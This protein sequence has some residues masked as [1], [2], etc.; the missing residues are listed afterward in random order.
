MTN[1]SL[2]ILLAFGAGF[3]FFFLK[4]PS[5][6]SPSRASKTQLG[7]PEA[8]ILEHKEGGSN[9]API[10]LSNLSAIEE[11]IGLQRIPIISVAG[12]AKLN[13]EVTTTPSC[14]YGDRDAI[15]MDLKAS[16]Q[17]K[18][19]ATLESL[20]GSLPPIVWDLSSALKGAEL[21][22]KSFDLPAVDPPAH[23]GFF[24]CTAPSIAE[25]CSD[26]RVMNINTIFTE[27]K[28]RDPNAGKILRTF[29]YQYFILDSKGLMAFKANAEGVDN[30]SILK[31]YLSARGLSSKNL[32]KEVENVDSNT[33]TLLS[34][35]LKFD[36]QNLKIE[37]PKF[38]ESQCPKN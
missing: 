13:V 15:D 29:F 12:K 30:F 26:K 28:R 4:Q 9:S 34:M 31:D 35:P 21:A 6:N 10:D 3:V 16:P 25:K 37:L 22:R 19:I 32:A 2:A 24:I 18:L 14:S 7:N 33:N 38:N 23:Y 11:R 17:N 36:G 20:S 1:K 27:H 5:E 8:L